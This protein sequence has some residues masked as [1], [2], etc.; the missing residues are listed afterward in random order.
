MQREKKIYIY[1]FKHSRTLLYP[2]INYIFCTDHHVRAMYSVSQAKTN[3][4]KSSMY[5]QSILLP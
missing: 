4:Y 1:K 5:I 3:H 2:Y